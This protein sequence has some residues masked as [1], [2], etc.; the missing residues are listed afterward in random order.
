M[1]ALASPLLGSPLLRTLELLALLR[2]SR[3]SQRGDRQLARTAGGS[4][5]FFDQ[6]KFHPGDDLRRVNWRAYLRTRELMVKLYQDDGSVP[7]RL[8]LDCSRSMLA[9]SH[10]GKETKF[11]YGKRLAASLLYIGLLRLETTVL[12]PFALELA[13]SSTYRHGRHQYAAAERL[14]QSLNAE[15][16]TG[17]ARVADQ[18][19]HR[20]PTPGVAIVI[21][22]FLGD[23]DCLQS[24]RQILDRGDELWLIQLWGPDD[25]S[26]GE[27]T[28]MR[29]VNVE[30]GATLP[31][32]L[33]DQSIRSYKEAFNR[34]S[35]TLKDLAVSRGGCYVGAATD[36]PL[37]ET[38]LRSMIAA[39]MIG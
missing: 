35:T 30:S 11:A 14:L 1:S 17:F 9:G 15:G 18:F 38:L 26:P 7:T 6:R 5:E 21:S 8:L 31:V 32:S 19:V 16:S 29:V 20:Y 13:P 22:D 2:R 28:H 36:D 23:A 25:R 33:D 39:G 34:Y 12:Q 24:L 37:N 27:R 4:R 10:A 3:V